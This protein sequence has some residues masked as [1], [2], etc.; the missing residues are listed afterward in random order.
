MDQVRMDPKVNTLKRRPEISSKVFFQSKKDASCFL[1]AQKHCRFS[2]SSNLKCINH[3]AVPHT[4]RTL[5]TT[6]QLHKKTRSE[7]GV[8]NLF[9]S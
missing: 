1:P 9:D 4:I 8:L 5:K 6:S 2:S 3:A 7:R